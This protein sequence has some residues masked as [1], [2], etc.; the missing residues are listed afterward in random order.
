[1]PVRGGPS[2]L[3]Q[4]RASGT[5][6]VTS[7]LGQPLEIDAFAWNRIWA[8]FSNSSEGCVAWFWRASGIPL[9][10]LGCVVHAC[11]SR[12]ESAPFAPQALTDTL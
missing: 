6:L 10:G 7:Q 11:E 8:T 2:P 4:R 3:V 12:C 5:F 9:P 1:M